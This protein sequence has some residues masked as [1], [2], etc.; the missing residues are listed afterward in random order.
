M[1]ALKNWKQ[2]PKCVHLNLLVCI[3]FE[4][5]IRQPFCGYAT[6]KNYAISR[7]DVICRSPTHLVG[8][9]SGKADGRL[10]HDCNVTANDSVVTSVV[11][12]RIFV[13]K[14]FKRIYKLLPMNQYVHV[15]LAGNSII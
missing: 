11:I 4:N 8:N 13:K 14:N 9:R 6:Q 1:Y 2:K 12:F 7:E 3:R 15:H 5:S 10:H